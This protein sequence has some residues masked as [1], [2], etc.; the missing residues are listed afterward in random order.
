MVKTNLSYEWWNH[1]EKEMLGLELTCLVTLLFS[2]LLNFKGLSTNIVWS[3]KCNKS[4]NSN[5][6]VNRHVLMKNI[7][8]FRDFTLNFGQRFLVP[9]SGNRFDY[10]D[11]K[12]FPRSHRGEVFIFR[13]NRRKKLKSFFLSWKYFSAIFLAIV[14]SK[15]SF[16]LYFSQFPNYLIRVWKFIESKNYGKITTFVFIMI[17]QKKII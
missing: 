11:V 4:K 10:K 2:F 8:F 17:H 9:V 16:F 13:K 1:E 7:F 14:V 5:K 6:T 15:G 12:V 3:S